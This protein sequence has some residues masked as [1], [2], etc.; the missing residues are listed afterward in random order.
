MAQ[1]VTSAGSAPAGEDGFDECTRAQ[2]G[3]FEDATT[4]GDNEKQKGT[5]EAQRGRTS[6]DTSASRPFLI[7]FTCG[8]ANASSTQPTKPQTKQST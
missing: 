3:S 4:T 2:E 1:R 5:L 6:T 7:S 8:T